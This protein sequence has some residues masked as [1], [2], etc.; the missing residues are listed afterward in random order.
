METQYRVLLY[1]KFVPVDNHEQLAAEHLEYCKNL[2]VLGRILIAPE[3][4]NGTLSG[5]F[6]QTEAY[7]N[8]LRS[9]SRFADT[10]FK[11]DTV[12]VQ[13]FHKIF[14]RAKA[15]LVTFRLEDDVKDRKSVV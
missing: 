4:I 6:E 2:G 12:D 1:Y 10:E 5:T 3:G 9:D 15:E 14:V 7:M 13:P 11:I 8:Y